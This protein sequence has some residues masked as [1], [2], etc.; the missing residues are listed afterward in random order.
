M[1]W[2]VGRPSYSGPVFVLP[3]SGDALFGDAVHLLR[4]DLHFER[5]SGMVHAGVQGLVEVG[6][7]IAM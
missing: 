7:G 3:V 2:I 4:A 1:R 5:L 6:R